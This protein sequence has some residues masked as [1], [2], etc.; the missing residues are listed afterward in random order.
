MRALRAT[1]VLLVAAASAAAS[2]SAQPGSGDGSLDAVA[3]RDLHYGDA[4][5]HFF[6]DDYF[7]A[8]VRTEAY[9]EQGRLG[10]HREDA[11]LLLGGLYL[12]F[13]QP[14]RAVEV[15]QR[16]LTR[17]SVPQPVRDRAWFH[18]GK[19]LYARGYFEES[20]DALRRA[21]DGLPAALAAERGLLLAQGLM[22]RGRYDE[23]VASLEGWEAPPSWKAYG[24]FNLGVALVRAGR[25]DEGLALLDEAGQV[26]A[27]T[28]VL[29]ALRDKANVALGY[30]RL[31]AG[32]PSAA[33]AALERVRL[34]GPQSSK[35]LLGA[36]WAEAAEE[37]YVEA[38][39]PWLE[40][41]GRG[42]LDAA[43]QESYLAVPYA[44]A[45]LE[46]DRQAAEYY[47]SAIEAFALEKRRLEESVRS[48][49]AGGMLQAVLTAAD[50]GEGSGWFWQ[51]STL[52][53]APE[54]RYLY[55][56]LA[57]N[58]FQ[59][60]LKYYRTLD[61]LEHNLARWRDS[62]SAY[63][64]MVETRRKAYSARLPEAE[65]RLAGVGIE[66]LD[67]RRDALHA[68][69]AAAD[70]GPSGAAAL[71]TEDE[72]RLL[73]MIARIEAGLAARPDDP[74]LEDA[75]DKARLAHGVLSWR[76]EAAQKE[77]AWHARRSLREL[78]AKL[79]EARTR[80]R[81]VTSA[82]ESV[83]ARN[84]A[85][86]ARIAALRPRI[87]ALSTRVAAVRERQ[88]RLLAELAIDEL[89]AQRAR[90][91]EYAVQ[92]RYALAALYDRALGSTPRGEE[93]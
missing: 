70:R 49:R 88:G 50:R 56:L 20:A 53:D 80:Y 85:F 71:A 62:L 17:D 10:P 67:A 52:P 15:F 61:F 78:D 77:R 1:T 72:L 11:E 35:A 37:R 18:V 55:H 84:D 38:L 27:R 48:I 92:A 73:D 87:D 28:E 13:G 58:E 36:G 57:G 41:R 83:P 79:F 30:A 5:F 54:S 6:Q 89:E 43:V 66:E 76:I 8:I 22:Y 75:R 34:E 40:L 68:R 74:S 25:Q 64:D 32:Q 93:P 14:S 19:V 59:E 82:M 23:A 7:E 81:A 65:E 42:M 90:L 2:A 26:E 4:L 33:R 3:I 63:A 9:R 21:G 51:L 16:L 44:Y 46:A 24:E 47:E 69:F 31:Q 12:S 39:A 45:R 86:A 29:K 60:A 91:D